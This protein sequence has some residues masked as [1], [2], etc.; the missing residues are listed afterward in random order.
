[1]QELMRAIYDVVD[2]R[3][4]TKIAEGA[5][6]SSRTLLSQK[7]NPDYDSHKMNVEELH[8]IMDFTKDIR[9]LKA[10]AEFFGFD[11][12]QRSVE[13]ADCLANATL[14]MASE[15]ADV[16]KAAI[17]ALDDGVVTRQ[18]AKRIEREGEE[19]KR[20]ID[21]VIATAKAKAKAR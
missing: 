18:E 16:T 11:L 15:A 10:W 12:V 13:P 17:E 1:M 21:V 2:E 5:S 6:F 20:K 14:A 8:R 4:A 7:A 3:G 9:P 19:A